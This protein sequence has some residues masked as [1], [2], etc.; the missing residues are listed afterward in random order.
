MQQRINKCRATCGRDSNRWMI[1]SRTPCTHRMLTIAISM[2]V[3][4]SHPS[5]MASA[6]SK[7]P[8]SRGTYLTVRR[9]PLPLSSAPTLRS[10]SRTPRCR[11]RRMPSLFRSC[12][13]WKLLSLYSRARMQPKL[14]STSPSWITWPDIW[15][16]ITLPRGSAMDQT[17][18]AHSRSITRFTTSSNNYLCCTRRPSMIWL[19]SDPSS[20]RS[21][22]TLTRQLAA[23]T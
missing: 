17:L 18:M 20:S 15:R 13:P 7:R 12:T 9:Q 2:R 8:A 21:R 19:E 11:T 22:R 23:R 1:C 4:S 14:R 5:N 3:R 6:V 10:T 16:P